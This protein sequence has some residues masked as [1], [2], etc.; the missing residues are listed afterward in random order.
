MK[1]NVSQETKL[2]L[3]GLHEN[4]P[5]EEYHVGTP[6]YSSSDLVAMSEGFDVWKWRQSVPREQTDAMALGSAT[7]LLL[8]ARIKD[9]AKLAQAGIAIMP[10]LNMRTNDGKAAYKVFVEENKGKLVLSAEDYDMARRMVDAVMLEPEV[11]GYFR[12]GISEPSIF[13]DDAETGLLLKCRPDYLR[14]AEGLSIN[15]KTMRAD[16]T[17]ERQAATLAYDW[18]S[19]FYCDVLRQHFGRNF[20]EIHVSVVKAKE[21][22]CRVHVHTID[23]EDLQNARAQWRAL[24]A[25]IPECERTN[26]WPAPPAT[27]TAIRIPNY[28]RR[29][30]PYV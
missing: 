20:D 30:C 8:E 25:K 19:S 9:D 6:G 7:H 22:P 2:K 10:D 28:S 14:P 27:L 17:F 1:T 13:V 23:D 11:A 24:L 21:G 29:I 15:F 16:M 4:M 26:C 5:N 3:V 12:G 18:A